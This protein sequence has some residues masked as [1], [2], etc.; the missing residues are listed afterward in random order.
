VDILAPRPARANLTPDL[1]CS[2]LP[3]NSIVQL[4]NSTMWQLVD[5]TITVQLTSFHQWYLVDLLILVE[6]RWLYTNWSKC[7]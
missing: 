4:T 1:E 7:G 3:Y 5:Y 2:N 6:T